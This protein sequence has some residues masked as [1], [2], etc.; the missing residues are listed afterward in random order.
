VGR[1]DE[2][3][4]DPLGWVGWTGVV[5]VGC[6]G[7]VYVGWTGVLVTGA[8][9]VTGAS[10]VVVTTGVVALVTA[11]FRTTWTLCAGRRRG[12]CTTTSG[13]DR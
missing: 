13:R 10:V 5:C 8:D 2:P 6:T 1:V 7:A 11:G 3:P 9:V 4:P 12:W